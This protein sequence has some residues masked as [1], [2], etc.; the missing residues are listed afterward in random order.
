M[1]RT[2]GKEHWEPHEKELE[3]LETGNYQELARNIPGVTFVK[4]EA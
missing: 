2:K 3:G 1:N 4:I